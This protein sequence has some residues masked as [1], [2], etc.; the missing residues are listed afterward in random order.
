MERRDEEI[1]QQYLTDDGELRALY[2]EH[3]EFKRK[4][5]TFRGKLHLTNQEEMEQKRLQKLKLASKDRMMELLHS[6][7]H[8]AAR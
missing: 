7:Q 2:E 5:E 3:Q 4:L 8:H 1:I 6:H